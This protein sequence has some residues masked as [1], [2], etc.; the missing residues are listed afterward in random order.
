MLVSCLW[1]QAVQYDLFSAVFFLL[2][3]SLLVLSLLLLGVG[4]K[5]TSLSPGFCVHRPREYHTIFGSLIF[6]KDF[7]FLLGW[8]FGQMESMDVAGV[9]QEAGGADSHT[10]SQVWVEYNILPHTSTSIIFPA[11][12]QEYYD[13]CIVTS[14]NERWESLGWFIYARVSVGGIGGGIIFVLFFVLFLC[15]CKLFLHGWYMTVHYIFFVLPFLLSLSMI[16]L[17]RCY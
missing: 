7:P 1:V 15:C 13:H 14:S 17:I 12:C 4:S 2:G 5:S 8:L 6:F 10:R 9:L 16:H 3:L 11:M